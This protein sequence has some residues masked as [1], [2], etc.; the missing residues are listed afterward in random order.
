MAERAVQ[1]VK[2]YLKK[3]IIDKKLVKLSIKEKIIRFLTV[4]NTMP[5]TVTSQSPSDRI[6]SYKL[7]SIASSINPKNNSVKANIKS[8][9]RF[10]LEKNEYYDEKS[11]D[12]KKGKKLFYRNHFKDYLKWLPAKIVKQTSK[13][14]YVVN[15]KV[16]E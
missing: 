2:K 14:L 6:F 13:Y 12:F 16:I 3:Y 7:R 9:V 15:V 1:T 8:K 11:M 5:S 4:Y 10:D